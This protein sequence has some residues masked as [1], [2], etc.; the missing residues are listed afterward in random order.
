MVPERERG[1]IA[2]RLLAVVMALVAGAAWIVPTVFLG[3]QQ[4]HHAAD[5]TGVSDRRPADQA[6]VDPIGMADDV[7][8][9]LSLQNAVQAAQVYFAESG[10]YTGFGP[11]QASAYDPTIRVTDGPPAA[12]VVS[13][14]AVTATSIV[15]VT[16]DAGGHVLC[17]AAN[18][19]TISFGRGDARAAADCTGG[20]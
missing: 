11:G 1:E 2:M 19:A 7:S 9:Q 6:P 20:W 12:G 5:L 4:V 17:A 3:R 14:R 8:A 18:G 13:V 10:T 16:E 15:L